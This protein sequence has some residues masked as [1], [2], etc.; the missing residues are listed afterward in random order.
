MHFE[1]ALSVWSELAAA[2]IVN[3]PSTTG[4]NSS[5]PY[6]LGIIRGVGFA[7]PDTLMTT[8]PECA[9]AFWRRHQ[10]IIYKSISSCRSIV[11]QFSESDLATVEDV[12]VC[13]TQFQQ[14]IDGVDYRV[15]VLDDRVFPSRI[16]CSD[17]DYRYSDKAHVAACSLPDDVSERCVAL[18]RT[19]GLRLSGIDLR[20]STAGDWYCFEVNPSPGFSYF[21]TETR[22][23]GRELAQ[24][25][26]RD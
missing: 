1:G 3:R 21:E 13:P 6:Q 11:A 9:V 23:I 10:R 22:S 14:F 16:E 4:S 19:L 7:V 17:D 2:T 20:R 18:T 5:K 8:D 25:L 24:F 15:H 12:T 26:M